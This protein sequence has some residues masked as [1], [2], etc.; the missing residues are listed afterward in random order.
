MSASEERPS[1]WFGDRVAE[2]QRATVLPD[3]LHP[4]LR[5]G[6]IVAATKRADSVENDLREKIPL[7][8]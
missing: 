1:L 4:R 6:V 7:P 8:E 3:R 2:Q 5:D